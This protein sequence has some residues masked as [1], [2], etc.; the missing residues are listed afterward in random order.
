MMR[1]RVQRWP[2]PHP[3]CKLAGIQDPLKVAKSVFSELFC[4]L[5]VL[6]LC[7]EQRAMGEYFNEL[8]QR[9]NK[10]VKEGSQLASSCTKPNA[11]EYTRM[12]WAVGWGCFLLGAN[13]LILSAEQV[14]SALLWS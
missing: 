1:S 10:L 6:G 12:L 11:K 8:K 2:G 7:S 3:N 9:A 5:G 13:F 4:P 14:R